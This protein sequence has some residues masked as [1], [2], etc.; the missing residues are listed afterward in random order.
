MAFGYCY[1]FKTIIP[2][3]TSLALQLFSDDKRRIA[4]YYIYV[5]YTRLALLAV[6]TLLPKWTQARKEGR[7]RQAI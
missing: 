6:Y 3:P 7:W 2:M 1:L 4:E 5:K